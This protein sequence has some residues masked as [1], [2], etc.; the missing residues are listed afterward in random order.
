MAESSCDSPAQPN[1]DT[2]PPETI[3]VHVLP[4]LTNG[5]KGALAKTCGRLFRLLRHERVYCLS[6]PCTRK[7]LEDAAF[8]EEVNSRI[9]AGKLALRSFE[10]AVRA[11]HF[12]SFEFKRAR[13]LFEEALVDKSATEVEKARAHL[14]L[15]VLNDWSW[16]GP[17]ETEAKERHMAAASASAYL[18]LCAG[19]E[20][21]PVRAFE[22]GYCH[23][24]GIGTKVDN[25]KAHSL[26]VSSANGGCAAAMYFLGW[27]PVL[28]RRRVT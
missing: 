16:G 8:R 26:F 11:F 19:D 12:P 5:E 24:G 15:I 13:T 7:Y 10:C 20:R 3:V 18:L 28:W 25:G 21:D 17:D 4:Y 14:S 1:L 2:L 9:P 22:I 6:S 23:Y 27:V